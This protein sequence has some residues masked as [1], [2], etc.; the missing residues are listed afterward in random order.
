MLWI[1]CDYFYLFTFVYCVLVVVKE[2]EVG[3]FQAQTPK[4]SHMRVL[5]FP[6]VLFMLLLLLFIP[7]S[8]HIEINK[9]LSVATSKSYIWVHK[10]MGSKLSLHLNIYYSCNHLVNSMFH[11][12]AAFIIIYK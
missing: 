8:L 7:L 2:R 5:F 12:E 1:F 9:Y 4:S 11:N 3:S 10:F 6:I